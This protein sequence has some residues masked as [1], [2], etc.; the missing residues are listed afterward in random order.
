MIKLNIE[1]Y[2]LISKVLSLMILISL[3]NSCGG[4]FQQ[5]VYVNSSGSLI[6]SAEWGCLTVEIS[7]NCSTSLE[8]SFLR[9]KQT[10][11]EP[12]KLD[13]RMLGDKNTCNYRKALINFAEIH[14]A[15]GEKIVLKK[16]NDRS[17]NCRFKKYHTSN[18]AFYSFPKPIDKKHSDDHKVTVRLSLTL[19]PGNKSKVFKASFQGRTFKQR[20]S[21][22]EMIEGV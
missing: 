13:I 3:F 2:R 5:K 19:M 10:C 16:D 9:K 7:L 20:L 1:E 12:F 8:R 14:Y 15:S 18:I 22:K 4:D 11:E 17:L 21:T 6:E